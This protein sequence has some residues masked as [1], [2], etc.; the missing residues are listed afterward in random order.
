MV[1][2]EYPGPVIRD[3]REQARGLRAVTRLAEMPGVHMTAEQRVRV[4]RAKDTGAVPRDD[5]E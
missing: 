2:A 4:I 5:C 1:G 3:F